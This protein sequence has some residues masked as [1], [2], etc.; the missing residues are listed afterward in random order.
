MVS[1]VQIGRVVVVR[2]EGA[3]GTPCFPIGAEHEVLDKKLAATIE[4]IG[5]G[6]GTV[7]AF[8]EIIFL[9]AHP[10]Q[11]APLRADLVA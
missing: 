10:R 1:E 2:P 4:E 3:S 5:Q 8:E 9:H 11:F 7:C 6:F